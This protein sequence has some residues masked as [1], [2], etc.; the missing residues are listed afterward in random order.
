MIGIMGKERIGEERSRETAIANGNQK[1]R[2]KWIVGVSADPADT[3][4][5]IEVIW[6]PVGIKAAMD[7]GRQNLK[8]Q[9]RVAS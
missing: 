6:I 8:W 9:W 5:E 1:F 3:K 2:R 4:I 7:K